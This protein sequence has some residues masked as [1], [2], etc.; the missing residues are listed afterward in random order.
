MNAPLVD[1]EQRARRLLTD[2]REH[3]SRGDAAA[4]VHFLMRA[5]GELGDSSGHSTDTLRAAVAEKLSSTQD[6]HSLL[7]K[8]ELSTSLPSS[9]AGSSQQRVGRSVESS[10][11]SSQQFFDMA[12]ARNASFGPCIHMDTEGAVLP[13]SM[14]SSDSF[15]CPHCGGVF[16]VVRREQHLSKWC[17]AAPGVS[18]EA[19]LDTDSDDGMVT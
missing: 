14:G 5:V 17:P 15:Q 11:A 8:L 1:K 19:Q 13:V 10:R 16:A 6:L 4:A 3:L 18:V 7:S 2:C 12:E 9:A